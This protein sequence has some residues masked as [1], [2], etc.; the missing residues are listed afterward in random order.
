MKLMIGTTNK[1]P[2]LSKEVENIIIINIKNDNCDVE[3][4]YSSDEVFNSFYL[5]NH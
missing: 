5:M 2:V 4:K 1:E 3:F